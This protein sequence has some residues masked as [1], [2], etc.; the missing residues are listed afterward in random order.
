M[1]RPK[2]DKSAIYKFQGFQTPHSN[3][4]RVPNDW[5]SITA[6]IDNLAEL[7]CVEYVLRHTWGYSE[8]GVLKHISNDEF[9]GGRRRKDG[10]RIDEGTGLSLRAVRDGLNKAV[11]HGFLNEFVD[12]SDKGRIK[13]Y[14][15]LKMQDP[16]EV[17]ESGEDEGDTLLEAQILGGQTLPPPRQSLPHRRAK[18]S[19]RT[20]K[21]TKERNFEEGNPTNTNIFELQTQIFNETSNSKFSKKRLE[22]LKDDERE[23][24]RREDYQ[25]LTPPTNRGFSA[26]GDVLKG[27]KIGTGRKPAVRSP[28]TALKTASDARAGVRQGKDK[29]G[30]P[31]PPEWLVEHITRYSIELHDASDEQ[32]ARNVGQAH[33]LFLFTGAEERRFQERL[34]EAKRR[35]LSYDI[36]KRAAGEDGEVFGQRNKMPY[37]FKVLRDV[38]GLKDIPA[39]Q[40]KPLRSNRKS[41][42][43][44][45]N[46]QLYSP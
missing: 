38:L 30:L 37:F 19:P 43:Y 29:T 35:T 46:E 44:N 45:V 32:I 36:E 34:T 18:E 8:Y 9:V 27:K 6:K 33:N 25:P 16:I 4:F 41:R 23:E 42:G 1:P 24:Q 2:K 31:E 12:D 28:K 10:S 3:Y 15:S 17:E 40:T 39:S 20:E 14:Y 26:V 21:D 22:N 13:K 7:K 11:D 5:P